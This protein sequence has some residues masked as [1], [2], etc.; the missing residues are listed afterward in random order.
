MRIGW[1]AWSID[2]DPDWN[3]SDDPE[4]ITLEYAH[5]GVGAFQ[6]SSYRKSSGDVSLADLLS[7]VASTNADLGPPIAAAFG[8]FSG[9][10]FAYR[11]GDIE[12]RRWLL[13]NGS[14][15]L[16]ATFNGAEATLR[17]Q[18]PMVV[19]MLN[20]LRVEHVTA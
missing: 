9:M 18:L 14:T 12:W 4:C 20:T 2:V 3:V 10:A 7:F 5:S 6:L 17:K 13:C 16:H 1:E 15:L 8:A 19:D 11:E